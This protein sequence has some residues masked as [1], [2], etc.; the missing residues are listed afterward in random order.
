VSDDLTYL[1]ECLEG[2][3]GPEAQEEAGEILAEAGEWEASVE[4]E[5]DRLARS[6]GRSLTEAEKDRVLESLPF[7]A[8]AV[9]DL[10]AEHS[11]SLRSRPENKEERMALMAE[12]AQPLIDERNAEKADQKAADG[13]AVFW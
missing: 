12:A 6:I 5:M 9:P 7:G 3:Y 13:G 11:E 10:V 2:H 8:D 4:A 1:N